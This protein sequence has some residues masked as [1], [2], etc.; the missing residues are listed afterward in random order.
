MMLFFSR[1][2]IAV[3]LF[4]IS[5]FVVGTGVWIFRDCWAPLPE[6]SPEEREQPDGFYRLGN[7]SQSGKDSIPDVDPAI[8]FLNRAGQEEL[9]RLPG[10]GPVMAKRILEFRSRKGRFESIEELLQVRGIGKKTLIRLK[11]HINLE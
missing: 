8:V 10:I 5:S 2:E 4:L 3:L 1:K 11:P 7:K 9:E 6:L